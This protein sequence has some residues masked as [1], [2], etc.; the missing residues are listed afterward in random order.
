MSC[1][2]RNQSH[3]LAILASPG[4]E[5]K[6]ANPY[7]WLLYS[8][9][10]CQVDDF[11]LRRAC[12]GR[13]DIMHLHWPE[14]DLNVSPN[15]IRAY[16]R[17]RRYL[18]A[19]D[20]MRLRGAKVFWTV[21]NLASHERRYPCLEQWY[22][23]QLLRR[24]DGYI[25]LTEGGR[26]EAMARFPSL[27]TLPGFVVPHPHYRG[28]YPENPA[29]DARAT[30]G[31]AK[32]AKVLLFF[33]QIR[34]YKNLPLLIDVFRQLHEPDAIL[35]IAGCPPHG[36][37]SLCEEIRSR[38]AGDSRIRIEFA[39]IAQERAYLYFSSADLVVLPYRDVH[40]DRNMFNSG[41]ALLALSFNRRIMAPNQGAMMAVRAQVGAD[42]VR[43][44][45]DFTPAELGAGLT[46]SLGP[47]RPAVAPLEHLDPALLAIRTF[48]A[49]N[50]VLSQDPGAFMAHA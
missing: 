22:W 5:A 26:V 11:S 3:Q 6:Q 25:A 37:L 2:E 33:G 29:V 12:F 32:N 4:L 15:A 30:L 46:W 41:I 19:I 27:H 1:L 28:A 10:P 48:E 35:Y 50:F 43:T 45:D 34:R 13:Y 47:R 36:D 49:Y 31:L 20:V 39:R 16:L 38:A 14:G 7:T 44:F 40:N 42:W 23:R 18:F 24:L 21:H 17:L 9:M 8:N